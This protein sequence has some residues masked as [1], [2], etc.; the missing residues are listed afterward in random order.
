MSVTLLTHFNSVHSGLSVYSS[1]LSSELLRV[2]PSINL[3]SIDGSEFWLLGRYRGG[4]IKS[5]ISSSLK[6]PR[7]DIVHSLDLHTIS[8]KTNVVT[9]VDLIPFRSGCYDD[10]LGR[11][12]Y[13]FICSRLKKMIRIYTLSNAVA[14]EASVFFDIDRD[15]FKGVHCGIDHSKYHVSLVSPPSVFSSGFNILHVGDFI[16]RK[17]IHLIIEALSLVEGDVRFIHVGNCKDKSYRLRCLELAS[18]LNVDFVDC[19]FVDDL[20]VFYNAAD[21]LVF[22][23]VDEGFGMPPMEA[24]ACGTPCVVSDIP[25]FHEIYGD[26]VFYSKLDEGYLSSVISKAMAYSFDNASLVKYADGFTWGKAAKSIYDD[27]RGLT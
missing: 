5:F 10:S 13:S 21:L 25:V 15:V 12:F 14:D 27:Y 20:N 2:D 4:I 23:S 8:P 24:L 18:S 19:G 1:M 7:S 9:L 17:N 3:I 16:P 6:H 11:R 22:P 26:S